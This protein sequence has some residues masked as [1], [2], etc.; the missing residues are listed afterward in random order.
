MRTVLAITGTRADYGLMRPIYQALSSSASIRLELAVTGMHLA[1]PFAASLQEIERDDYCPRHIVDDAASPS[2]S[3][4]AMARRLGTW[5]SR[6]AELMA[7]LSPDV[8][9]V[10]GDR[11]EMLAAAAAAA[12]LD[13]AVVHM[14]GGDVSGSIDDS[15]RKAIT[16]FAHVHLTT[17]A[18]SSARVIAMG[19]APARVFEVGE[20][21]LDVIRTLD[22]VPR[23]VLARDLRLDPDAPFL[24]A[25]Q[26]PV[27]N[28]ADRA[29][30]QVRATL[31]ALARKGIQTVFTYPNTD[32]GYEAIVAVLEAWRGHAFLRVVEHLGSA[33]YLSLMR[34]AAAVVGNSSSGI[35]EA[36]SFRV[37]AV[38]IGTR[39]H[40]RTRACNVIDV[41]YD[42]NEIEAGIDRAL[43]DAGFRAGL[44]HCTSPYGDGRCA[45]RTLAIIE[46]LRLDAGLTAKWL[47]RSAAI[48]DP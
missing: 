33:V 34:H 1:A 15:I 7:S 25:T 37:P 38:N 48:V 30:A 42:A 27:T 12:H 16:S 20:P 29:G 26:H 40:A 45:E 24:L 43:N 41:G 22:P 9:L 31:E 11:G 23:A 47:V 4:L 39:Q 36:P 44:Q 46:R 17:C 21:A 28:E 6:L 14:S 3:R 19:E 10:Q 2:G 18:Q 5:T 32:A 8:V 13:I 35:L